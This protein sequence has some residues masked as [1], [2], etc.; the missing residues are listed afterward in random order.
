MDIKK[1]FI[2]FL[3]VILS[4][5]SQ[6]QFDLGIS[7]GVRT[8]FGKVTEESSPENT[9]RFNNTV[10]FPNMNI[11][12]NYVL[13][14]NII[15]LDFERNNLFVSGAD[16]SKNVLFF[17]EL[18]DGRGVIINNGGRAITFNLKYGRQFSRNKWNFNLIGQL[19]YSKF[20]AHFDNTWG[21]GAGSLDSL[22]NKEWEWLF[23][24]WGD[25]R[26]YNNLQTFGLGFKVEIEYNIFH[27]FFLTLSN[28]VN[29]GLLKVMEKDYQTSFWS[30]P[31]PSKNVTYLNRTAYYGSN[32]KCF[33]GLKYRFNKKQASS[34]D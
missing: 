16:N 22:G 4:S 32:Y 26:Y 13:N 5:E 11:Q 24:E 7:T 19:F 21:G 10:S 15:G 17:P 28:E 1:L 20:Q 9:F 25:V 34:N 27:N 8:S 14:K 2:F 12:L 23:T 29:K 6:G 33:I 31:E 3:L 30:I 18:K